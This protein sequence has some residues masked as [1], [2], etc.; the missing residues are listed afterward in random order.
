MTVKLLTEHHSEFL[1]LKGGC[2]G[3]SESTHVKMPYSW[4]SHALAHII[5]TV[6][7][8]TQV[9]VALYEGG[10]EVANVIFAATLAD[11]RKAWFKAANVMSSSWID[12]HSGGFFAEFGID[13]YVCKRVLDSS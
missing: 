5:N 6:S 3:S 4:N 7:L 2:R 1:S 13:G 12:V 8:Q 10:Q 9:K 11:S